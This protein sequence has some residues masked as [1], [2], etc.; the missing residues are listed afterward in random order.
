MNQTINME[1]SNLFSNRDLSELTPE[2]RDQVREYQKIHNRLRVL[3]MQMT[4]IQEET[5]D[6]LEI[7]EKLRLKEKNNGEV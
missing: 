7:L 5:H 2:Q 4:E 3:K 1:G 6:L